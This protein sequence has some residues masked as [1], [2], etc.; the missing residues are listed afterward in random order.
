MQQD[1]KLIIEIGIAEMKIS[2]AP[3]ILVTRGLGSCVG[4]V[5]YDSFKK[6]GALAHPMLPSIKN[7]RFKSNPF[8]FVDSSVSLMLEEFKKRGSLIKNLT[9]KIFGGAHMFASI[10]PESPLNIGARNISMTR[11]VL[12]SFGI[13]IIAEDVGG[14][15]GRTIFFDLDSGKVKVR[16]IF[17]GEREF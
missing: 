11:E 7:A 4:I 3:N 15:F 2:E 6:I 9:A 1:S 5:L 12:N 16:T 14:N 8:K 13:K 17:Q 10:P